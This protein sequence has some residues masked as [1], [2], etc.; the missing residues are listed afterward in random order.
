MRV[1]SYL[2]SWGRSYGL[3]S[4]VL[5]VLFFVLGHA[6]F[7]VQVDHSIVTTSLFFPEAIDWA[8]QMS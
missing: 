6:S 7:L 3:P 5:A 2:S 1:I 4:L 8:M